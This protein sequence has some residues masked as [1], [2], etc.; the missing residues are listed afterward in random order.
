MVS[1]ACVRLGTACAAAQALRKWS[2]A[3]EASSIAPAI[4][5][6]PRTNARRSWPR[7]LPQPTCACP[8]SL[9]ISLAAKIAACCTRTSASLTLSAVEAN[10]THAST[11][12]LC[13][14]GTHFRPLRAA[15]IL[16]PG[17]CVPRALSMARAQR[18]VWPRLEPAARP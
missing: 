1:M 13:C 8:A 9:V 17:R 11:A 3:L 7:H 2:R 4:G 12:T 6:G 5:A 10:V 16:A 14:F 15:V 18:D